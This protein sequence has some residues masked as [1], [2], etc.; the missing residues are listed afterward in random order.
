[1]NDFPM[2]CT[3][4]NVQH[5][6]RV[7]DG[8]PLPE[9]KNFVPVSQFELSVSPFTDLLPVLLKPTTSYPDPT[10][11]FT[12][13]DDYL[14]KRDSI[15]TIKLKSPASKIFSNPGS[16]NKKLRGAFVTSIHGKKY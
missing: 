3:P 12:F 8:Q 16:T 10:F 14:L 13:Q 7:Y 15:N 9:E 2:A 1:M 4:L 5:L 6:Q 11:G